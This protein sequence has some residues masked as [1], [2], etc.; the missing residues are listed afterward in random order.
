M[1]KRYMFFLT[2]IL[3]GFLLVTGTVYAARYT[4]PKIQHATVDHD[5][6]LISIYGERFRS[7]PKVFL[8]NETLKVIKSS[9]KHIQ[10]KLPSLKP[11]THRLT[12][13]N[14]RSR[15]YSTP[16]KDTVNLVIGI[17]GPKGDKGDPG[18]QGP[19]GLR[20]EKGLK[21]DRGPKGEPG[22]PGPRGSQG[23]PGERGAQGVQGPA[24]PQGEPGPAGENGLSGIS[25]Y[26]HKV[27][28]FEEEILKVGEAIELEVECDEGRK[29]LTGGVD[30]RR[31]YLAGG[32]R[33]EDDPD[34]DFRF[35]N[36]FPETDSNWVVRVRNVGQVEIDMLR[37]EVHVICAY[38]G[39]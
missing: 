29:I 30:T 32:I 35:E 27:N 5:K 4:K 8:G 11:G 14:T 17:P 28:S 15:N 2:V 9:W 34:A 10:A 39:N 19:Q 37:I 36:S 1:M 23:L 22:L 25:G 20:G 26:N 31:C 16:A 18:E 21:G 6:K 33:C 24:G 3:T 7:N 13:L 12:V 38:V